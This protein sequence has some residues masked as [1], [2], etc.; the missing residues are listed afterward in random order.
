M[1]KRQRRHASEGVMSSPL[2]MH[3]LQVPVS[4]GNSVITSPAARGA[5]LAINSTI[6]IEGGK[7]RNTVEL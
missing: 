3:R 2:I 6:V 7:H 4:R 5:G 1:H